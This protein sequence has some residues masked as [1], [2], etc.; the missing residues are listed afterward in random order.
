MLC[1][2]SIVYWKLCQW[3]FSDIENMQRIMD[4]CVGYAFRV[5]WRPNKVQ[6][7][8]IVKS[9]LLY[10]A[11]WATSLQS[12]KKLAAQAD[13]IFLRVFPVYSPNNRGPDFS[14]TACKYQLI[15]YKPWQR[16]QE[17]ARGNQPGNDEIYITQWKNF[18]KPHM[19]RN[20]FLTDMI[21]QTPCRITRKMT[22]KQNILHE[23][24]LNARNGC[25]QQI[26]F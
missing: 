7:L 4:S 13:N 8:S 25:F 3:K 26:L 24:F 16:T 1:I 19:Q 2:D 21:S 17:N 23:N 18:Q 11:I 14:L 20:M 9:G 15:R 22:L 5:S 12:T 6:F 10:T